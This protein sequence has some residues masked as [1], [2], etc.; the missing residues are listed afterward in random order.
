VDKKYPRRQI[1]RLVKYAIGMFPDNVKAKFRKNLW[2]HSAYAK[3]LQRS[4]LFYGFPSP[5]KLQV[6]YMNTIRRQSQEIDSLLLKSDCKQK[7]DVVLVLLG[8]MKKG[9]ETLYDLYLEE[10]IH[11]IYIFSA[12]DNE[13]F[14]SQGITSPKNTIKLTTFDQMQ[15]NSGR[16]LLMIRSGDKLH[17]AAIPIFLQ[18]Q[19]EL[20][21]NDA[22][23]Y[24]DCDYLDDNGKRYNAEL[25]PDWN[26]DL[27]LSTGYIKTAVFLYGQALI[28]DLICFLRQTQ[29]KN[30]IPNWLASVYL[31]KLD[32]QIE[33]LAYTLLHQSPKF[34]SDWDLNLPESSKGYFSTI[35]NESPGVTSLQWNHLAN[36]LV[37]LVI[38]TKN[39]HDLVEKCINSILTKTSYK[40]FEILLIDNNSDDS[41]SLKYFDELNKHPQ[42]RVLKFPYPFNYSAINNFAMEH[43]TGDIIGLVNNDVEVITPDWLSLMVGHVLRDD[44]GCVGAKLLY[45]DGR[46]QHAGVV[47][48]YGGGAGHAHKYFPR[49]HPGYMNRLVASHNFSAVTAAC[50]LVKKADYHAV[51]G[52]DEK[53]LTVAFN[54]VDFCLKVLQLGK[55]NLYCAEAELFHHESVSRGL[56]LS[57]EKRQRFENE[58]SYI[59]T[60]WSSYIKKD[61]AYNSNLTLRRENFAIRD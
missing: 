16:P 23:L 11:T 12:E 43:A 21:L 7:I 33:H 14:L 17:P 40:N 59:Q 38:P 34:L 61:P 50:L 19:S 8:D 20:N 29:A 47:M 25:L 26:P 22:I 49:Y 5:E 24:C 28:G 46:I 35:A 31:T 36:N 54:D 53:N 39:S 57:E 48:G 1:M 42:I 60:K 2:L 44:I 55:R 52:L 41:E 13:P 58:L 51:G 27:Q 4:G 30:L 18:K 15:E 9:K 3:L 32:V 56:D 10:R 45:P 6:L 37:S